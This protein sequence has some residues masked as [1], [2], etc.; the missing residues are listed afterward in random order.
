M[1][2]AMQHR[3]RQRQQPCQPSSAAAALPNFTQKISAKQLSAKLAGEARRSRR[4]SRR[5]A[6]QRWQHCH[7]WCGVAALSA[8]A[9]AAI[10]ALSGVLDTDPLH[11]EAPVLRLDEPTRLDISDKVAACKMCLLTQGDRGL[12]PSCCARRRSLLRYSA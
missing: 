6:P 5:W 1:G 9:V 4:F 12:K 2:L 10:V 7:R 3:R 8:L 11:P